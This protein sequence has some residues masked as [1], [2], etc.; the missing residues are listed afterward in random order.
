[1]LDL[2]DS[3]QPAGLRRW[4]TLSGTSGT[5]VSEGRRPRMAWLRP[6]DRHVGLKADLHYNRQCCVNYEDPAGWAERFCETH[7]QTM[8]D[9]AWASFHSAHQADASQIQ[10]KRSSTT[11]SLNGNC[12]PR[13]K[14]SLMP[15]PMATNMAIAWSGGRLICLPTASKSNPSIG[16]ES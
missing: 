9:D 5:H 13:G 14:G 16:Q 12:P 10:A 11:T 2:A 3:A 6:S 15:L 8:N 1:M 7:H 4:E